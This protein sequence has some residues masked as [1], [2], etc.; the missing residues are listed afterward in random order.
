MIR[1]CVRRT[2]EW[3]DEAAF[4]AQLDPA[5]APKVDAWNRTFTMPF[6]EFRHRVREIARA[7]L[8]AVSG[9]ACSPWNEIPEGALVIPIDDDDWLSPEAAEALE[10]ARDPAAFGYYWI[11]SYLEVPINVRHRLGL[12]GRRLFPRRRPYWTCSSNN[13]AF[14][15]SAEMGT[16]LLKHS[17]AS[18][19]F[20]G[21]GAALVRRLE[22]RLSV[23]NRTLASITSLAFRRR[24][25]GR[26]ALIR[27][28]R[29]Y[30]GLYSRPVPRDIAWCQPYVAM[31]A[32]L[33][34]ELRLR[35][36]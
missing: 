19:W 12:I 30:R 9:A 7:S 1:I 33:M 31:M 10:A 35:G 14:L 23:Q 24:S 34:N 4:R 32:D 22:R 13:Y 6:H 11:S 25:I 15:K 18:P 20:D 2:V 29:T 5:L 3:R 28:Y 16:R 27:K 21:A 36:R 17:H 26:R 8:G